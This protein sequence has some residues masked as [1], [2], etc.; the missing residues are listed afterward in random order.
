[1]SRVKIT[2]KN[3][4]HKPV[5]GGEPVEALIALAAAGG[6]REHLSRGGNINV[7]SVAG[8]TALHA[9]ARKGSGSQVDRAA[10]EALIAAGIDVDAVNNRNETALFRAMVADVKWM[11]EPLLHAGASVDV[12]NKKGVALQDV[13]RQK[14][15]DVLSL[16]LRKTLDRTTTVA[17]LRRSPHRL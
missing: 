7:S 11:M 4:C 5:K 17:S 6:L 12:V 15:E 16:L 1:M 3:Q 9:L 13:A 2:T 8:I 10:F 14:S